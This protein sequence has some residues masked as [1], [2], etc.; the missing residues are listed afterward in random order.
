[1]LEFLCDFLSKLLFDFLT[2]FLSDFVYD[3]VMEFLY[4]YNF[5]MDFLIHLRLE[6]LKEFV[7]VSCYLGLCFA[8]LAPVGNFEDLLWK[9]NLQLQRTQA[10]LK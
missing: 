4:N 9:G 1:M 3:L 8:I 5:P 7:N 6:F 10:R 2:E